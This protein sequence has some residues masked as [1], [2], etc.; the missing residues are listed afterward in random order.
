MTEYS[1]AITASAQ[2]ELDAL[3][4]AL[5]DRIDRKIRALA[6]TPRP[7]G[8]IKL[9]GYRNQWRIRIGDYRAIYIIDDSHGHVSVTRVAHRRDV[10]EP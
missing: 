6:S 10:Y 9:S 8:C 7:S 4:D 5:F 2:K 3:S 1:L